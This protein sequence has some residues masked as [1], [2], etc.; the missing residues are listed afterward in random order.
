MA[1]LRPVTGSMSSIDEGTY[2]LLGAAS[3]LGK[4]G[5]RLRG[6]ATGHS[7][8]PHDSPIYQAVVGTTHILFLGLPVLPVGSLPH[9]RN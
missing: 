3:F 2:A 1:D 9:L 8:S 6:C 5:F 4:L 7:S